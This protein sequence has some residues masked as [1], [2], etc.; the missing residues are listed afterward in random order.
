LALKQHQR[1]TKIT[2]IFYD[3]NLTANLTSPHAPYLVS[4]RLLNVFTLDPPPHI[5]LGVYQPRETFLL[6]ARETHKIFPI[7]TLKSESGK[8]AT[9]TKKMTILLPPYLAINKST[10]NKLYFF[11]FVLVHIN[12]FDYHTYC[13]KGK[14]RMLS[15]F[16]FF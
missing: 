4:L 15:T 13:Q 10:I 5:T 2:A 3:P 6:H 11:S 7:E 16:F 1:S 14:A 12:I 9:P 8:C